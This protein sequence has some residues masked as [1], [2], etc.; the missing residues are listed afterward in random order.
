MGYE[1]EL[2]FRA[3]PE[4]LEKMGRDFPADEVF[5]M[6]TTYYDTDDLL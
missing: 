2:K 5:R 3:N 6:R 4:I 1:F